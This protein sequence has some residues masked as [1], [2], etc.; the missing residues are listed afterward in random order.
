M[1]YFVKYKRELQ[2]NSHSS[3]VLPAGRGARG[4]AA[5]EGSYDTV[6]TFYYSTIITVEVLYWN[7]SAPFRITAAAQPKSASS[8]QCVAL[9]FERLNTTLKRV[10]IL[11]CKLRMVGTGMAHLKHSA[12]TYFVVK[13]HELALNKNPKIANFHSTWEAW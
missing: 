13:K 1:E 5:S 7:A 6:L 12:T 2:A 8:S 9:I 11:R 3:T 10:S 4:T